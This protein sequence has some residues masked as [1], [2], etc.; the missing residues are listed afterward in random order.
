[1]SALIRLASVLLPRATRDRYREQWLADLRDAE[2]VGLRPSGIAWGALAFALT[3]SRPWPAVSL[4]PIRMRRVAFALTLVGAAI[5]LTYYPGFEYGS[6]L[7]AGLA[8]TKFV[9]DILVLAI[10]VL[11][12]IAGLIL[13]SVTRGT[14]SA[15]RVSVWLL[16]LAATAPLGALAIGDLFSVSPD[17]Y[18]DLYIYPGALAYAAAAALIVAAFALRRPR[19]AH[20]RPRVASVVVASV[21]V[22]ALGTASWSLAS[23]IWYTREPLVA[24]EPVGSPIYE[25]WLEIKTAFEAQVAAVLVGSAV[26]VIVV[27]TAVVLAGVVHRGIDLRT[28][29][30]AAAFLLLWGYVVLTQY[31]ALAVSV[32]GLAEASPTLLSILRIAF[33][34]TVF[35]AVD[36]IRRPW[37]TGRTEVA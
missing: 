6:D 1:V 30:V 12:P 36:G 13:V 3:A 16:A 11:G 23:S 10:Q 21:A 18:V 7:P 32:S 29:T 4:D 8:S 28:A 35:A 31:L 22:A 17:L 24:S 15:E 34:A 26:A 9:L 14:P 2:E 20:P 33:I 27:A 25:Q 19:V 5:G 37:R